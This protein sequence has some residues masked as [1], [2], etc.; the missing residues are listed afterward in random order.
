[1]PHG[2]SQVL[3][4]SYPKD[5]Q[6]LIHCLGSLKKFSSG[7]LPP[8]VCVD[9]ADEAS[10]RSICDQ[11]YPEAIV[12]VKAGRPGRG[13][14]RAQ[15]A[16]MECDL[17]CPDADFIFLL[18]SDCLITAPWTPDLYFTPEG[19]PAM[20]FTTYEAM[21]RAGADAIKW[22]QCT[23]YL[24]GLNTP[25]EWMRRLPLIYPKAMFAPFRDHLSKRHGMAFEDLIHDYDAR[26]GDMSESNLM[27]AWA[28]EYGHDYFHWVDIGECGMNGSQVNGWPNPLLQLWSHGGLDRPTE[29]CVDYTYTITRNSKGEKPRTLINRILYGLP[30]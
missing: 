20:L 6:F 2:S 22:R 9:T 10:A 8:V 23:K 7:F 3:I 21:G 15:C 30:E 25:A 11:S 12:R 24:L 27:G 4:C 13:W 28:W 5:Y 14:M 26:F 29:A 18:G 19:L 1:M 16:M 17:L